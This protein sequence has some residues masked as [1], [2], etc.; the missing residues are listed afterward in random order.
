[1]IHHQLSTEEQ[2]ELRIL[3]EAKGASIRKGWEDV[4]PNKCFALLDTDELRR[5]LA[6]LTEQIVALLLKQ[7]WNEAQAQAVGAQLAAL[8]CVEPEL[9]G[10]AQVILMRELIEKLPPAPRGLV[11]SRCI[12]LLSDLATGFVRQMQV[13][14]LTRQEQLRLSLIK[15]REQ[16][17]AA[18]RES[19]ARYRQILEERAI[20]PLDPDLTASVSARATAGNNH[21]PH[22]TARECEVLQLM[23]RG[24]T[25]Q[26]IAE[27]LH[28]SPRTVQRHLKGIYSKLHVS[29]RVEAA[30]RAVNLELV[31]V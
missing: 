22:L 23:V 16:A 26:I 31:K 10:R 19:E 30:V 8:P 25:D 11:R 3:L 1:M 15:A 4:L 2:H 12:R 27:A 18:Q 17:E 20:K 28:I 24:S 9:L 21:P 6:S 14:I 29:S 7:K 13:N 5:L